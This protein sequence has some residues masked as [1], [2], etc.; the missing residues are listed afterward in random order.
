MWCTS[1]FIGIWWNEIPSIFNVADF[2]TGNNDLGSIFTEVGSFS[3]DA[4]TGIK[5]LAHL[6][7]AYANRLVS[8]VSSNYDDRLK[9]TRDQLPHSSQLRLAYSVAFGGVSALVFLSCDLWDIR[10]QIFRW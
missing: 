6:V 2:L 9:C 10:A 1:V 8:L 4:N 5:Q 7:H 3:I